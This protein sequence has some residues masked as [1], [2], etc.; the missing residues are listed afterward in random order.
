M[1]SSQ[2]LRRFSLRFCSSWINISLFKQNYYSP[3]ILQQILHCSI[4]LLGIV[5]ILLL[6]DLISWFILISKIL[7]FLFKIWLFA[8]FAQS[9]LLHHSRVAWLI[10]NEGHEEAWS[11]KY[12]FQPCLNANIFVYLWV[13][14]SR[15]LIWKVWLTRFAPQR[16]LLSARHSTVRNKCS[17]PLIS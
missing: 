13:S 5:E 17:Q 4:K 14:W 16:S 15:S 6:V 9:V 10:A 1:A 3:L 12:Q 8:N 7:F 11:S 2:S